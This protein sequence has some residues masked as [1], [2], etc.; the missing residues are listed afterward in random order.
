MSS[1]LED[2]NY[3]DVVE[4]VSRNHLGRPKIEVRLALK[5]MLMKRGIEVDS[6]NVEIVV[7]NISKGIE[8]PA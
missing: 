5:N 2:S 4:W 7:D 3:A 1:I 6:D 8:Q